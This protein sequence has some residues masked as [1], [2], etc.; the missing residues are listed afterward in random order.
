MGH[1]TKTVWQA[2]ERTCTFG[3]IR[4]LTGRNKKDQ[5]PV[6]RPDAVNVTG[7]RPWVELATIQD[8]FD[9]GVRAFNCENFNP[10]IQATLDRLALSD[11]EEGLNFL[12]ELVDIIDA[13]TLHSKRRTPF[14]TQQ[15]ALQ[16]LVYITR[17]LKDVS[18]NA[19]QGSC[20]LRQMIVRKWLF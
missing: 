19:G 12:G 13:I 1:C 20:F 2:E 10:K 6:K 3:E 4:K 5:D 15:P 7:K 8:R 18:D 17:A 16:A 11:D 9:E 14:Q